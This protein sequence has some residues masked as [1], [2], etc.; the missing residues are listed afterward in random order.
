MYQVMVRLHILDY[1]YIIS[2]GGIQLLHSY[3][4]LMNF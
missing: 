3:E 4:Y 2:H 1:V